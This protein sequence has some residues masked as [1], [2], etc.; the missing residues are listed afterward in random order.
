VIGWVKRLFEGE[1]HK[2]FKEARKDLHDNRNE[3]QR[4]IA[5]ARQSGKK[6][7]VALKVAEQAL[8]TLERHKDYFRDED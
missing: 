8:K 1:S 4:S 3:M 2:K 7:S 5:T 6:S